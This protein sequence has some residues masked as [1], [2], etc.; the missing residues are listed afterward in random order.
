MDNVWQGAGPG[1]S[2]T[3]KAAVEEGK[4]LVEAGVIRFCDERKIDMALSTCGIWGL[5]SRSVR[6][7]VLPELIKLVR[8]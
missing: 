3:A 5:V 4:L 1:N 2:E 6:G 8:A 7:S